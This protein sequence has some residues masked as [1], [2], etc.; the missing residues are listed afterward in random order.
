VPAPINDTG[1]AWRSA[2]GGGLLMLRA[3]GLAI[4]RA[5][6]GVGAPGASGP[7]GAVTET[8]ADRPGAEAGDAASTVTPST[9]NP[10]ENAARSTEHA[11][12]GQND[13]YYG[14][15]AQAVTHAAEAAETKSTSPG[16]AGRGDGLRRA[17][18]ALLEAWDNRGD[19][20][21]DSVDEMVGPV[22][23]L[24]AVLGSSTR[25]CAPIRTPVPRSDTKQSQVLAMLRR[26][27]GASGPQIAAAM[28]WAPHTVRGFLAGLAKK[29][30]KVEVLERVRQV[31]PNKTGTKGSYTVYRI[32][33]ASRS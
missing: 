22:A 11:Q 1:Y 29:G 6:E 19:G 3:T 4:A 7:I 20:D 32:A 13:P 30:I 33:D 9:Y 12:R 26:N 10:S 15:T 25:V 21:H 28:G 16:R 24:R 14:A 27:E 31:G 2:E 8:S 17:A 5:T 23:A 18:Q